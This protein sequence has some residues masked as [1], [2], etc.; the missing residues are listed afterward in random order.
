MQIR[1]E[2]T[3]PALAGNWVDLSD[4]WTRG[5]VRAW[6][7]GALAGKDEVTFPLLAQ[8]LVGVHLHLADGTLV[9]DAATLFERIDE[10]DMRLVRW[11]S[12]GVMDALKELMALG[13]GR[14]RLLFDG[15]EIA[16]AAMKP[17]PR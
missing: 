2:C 1:I 8:K 14:R 11:L 5:E 16:V 17:T 10:L 13:E 7:A 4:V 3:L 9:E 15:V 6:Y 12:L